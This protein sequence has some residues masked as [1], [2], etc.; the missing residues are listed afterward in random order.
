MGV[1]FKNGISYS[2]G[3][4]N[5]G[6][7]NNYTDLINKPRINNIV[8]AGNKTT[9]DLNIADGTTVYVNN[10]NELAVGVITPAQINDLFN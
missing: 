4:S 8:L 9:T 7:T 2:G 3:G 5:S 10:E 6:G 1:I